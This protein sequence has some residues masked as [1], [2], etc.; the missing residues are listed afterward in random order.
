[1]CEWEKR[2]RKRKRLGFTFKI[3]STQDVVITISLSFCYFFVL[4]SEEWLVRIC[5]AIGAITNQAFF[6]VTHDIIFAFF[7]S[8]FIISTI[9]E[10]VNDA[11]HKLSVEIKIPAIN[12]SEKFLTKN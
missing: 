9:T 4:G 2:K 7:T 11:D 5:T 6:A 8:H 1:L 3:R 10:S 12:L